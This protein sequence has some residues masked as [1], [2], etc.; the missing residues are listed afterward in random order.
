MKKFFKNYKSTIIL[1]FAIIIGAIVGIIFKEKAVVLSPLG[2]LFL[3]L[4]FIIIVPLVFLNISTAIAKMTQPKRFGKIMVGIISVF[5]ITSIVAVIIGLISTLPIKLVST[6]DGEQIKSSLEEITS[7]DSEG[8]EDET[9]I[10]Q[11]TVNTLTVNDFSGLLSRNNIIA[12]IVFAIIFGIAAQMS[13]KKAK[14]VVDFLDSANEIIMNIVKIIMY[15]APIGLGCYFASLVGT[16]GKEI[17]IGYVKTFV[18]YTIVAVLFYFIIYTL[19]AFISAGKK[20]V[21]AFWRNIIPPT[22]TSLATCSSAASIPVNI[23]SAKN[24]GVSDDIAETLIPFGTSFH[25]D[26]S[27]IGSVFK[28]MFLV[29]LF[30][31]NISSIGSVLQI[32][33]VA[34]VAT[35]LVS[36]VPIGG[37]TISEMLIITMMGYPIAALP[38][39]TIIATIIDPPA[40]MLNVVG[41]SSSSMLAARIVDGKNWMDKKKN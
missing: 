9:S 29:C 39:L 12:I 19:Y 37:G 28:I 13:G 33:G 18:I 2:D 40:T 30:G 38:I 10:L 34:L 27:I 25:K 20:G 24:I 8:S 17:A 41:D 6:E 4:M 22:V 26:G 23:Q 21:R 15:Y 35:L 1:L 7:S 5:I 32:L 11:R 14:P 16:F 36:A 31:T 3:N